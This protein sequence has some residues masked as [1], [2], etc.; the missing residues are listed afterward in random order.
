M[1]DENAEFI[2]NANSR[3]AIMNTSNEY[4]Y[5]YDGNF[6]FEEA[7]G[8]PFV[9]QPAH[10]IAVYSIAY[11]LI[12]IFGLIGNSFVIAVIF[13]DPSMRNVTNYFILNLAVADIFVALL[14]V[15]IT[16]LANIF[17]GKLEILFP[18]KT[19]FY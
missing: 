7:P 12:F 13:K 19:L 4:S 15:P 3:I 18:F 5:E 6:S 17:T 10:L 8:I 14:C 1:D 2:E 11:G 9:K 16:L